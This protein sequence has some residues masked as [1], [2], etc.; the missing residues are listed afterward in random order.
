[1][2][3]A[4]LLGQ[5]HQLFFFRELNTLFSSSLFYIL[6]ASRPEGTKYTWLLCSILGAKTSPF[7]PKSIRK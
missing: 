2:I 7:L 1:M 5:Q 3:V 4:Y 6:L